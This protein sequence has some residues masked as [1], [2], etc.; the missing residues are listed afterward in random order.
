[1]TQ[2]TGA[3]AI[4]NISTPGA[5]FP[6]DANPLYSATKAGLHL[7]TL[8][9]RRH[10]RTTPVRVL[11]VFPPALDTQ[12]ARSL[13]VESQAAHGQQVIDSVAARIVDGILRNEERILPH[14]QSEALYAAAAPDIDSFIET[15]NAGVRRRPGW[16]SLSAEPEIRL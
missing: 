16:D 9:L 14:P 8:A 1:V 15:V 5:L 11:E 6:L 13:L 12:L 3:A 2:A 10:L 7:F 4:V